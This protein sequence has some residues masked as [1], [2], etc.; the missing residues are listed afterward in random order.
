MSNPRISAPIT[1][2][3]AVL[4]GV[5]ILAPS[6]TAQMR[7]PGVSMP[8]GFGRGVNVSFAGR[9]YSRA[10]G[11]GAIFLG[12][13]FY[14]DYPVAPVAVPPQFV[15]V[16]PAPPVETQPEI[17]SEPLMIELQ[18]NRYVRFGGRQRSAER[19]TNAPPDYAEA[20]AASA[21]QITRQPAELPPAV[22]I[23][24]DGHREQVPEYAIVG[25]TIYAS[26][27]YWQSG[28]WTKNIQVSALNIPATIQANHEA[29]IRFTLPSAPNEVVTRP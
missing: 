16:Q 21:P 2:S 27:D 7:G 24:K 19:G 5:T 1:F 9:P 12:D 6:S 20:D 13:P 18:G 25:S 17:K 10:F 22:L 23:F 29:G 15:V 14:A 8:S 26:G 4:L 11:A 3:L 28:H